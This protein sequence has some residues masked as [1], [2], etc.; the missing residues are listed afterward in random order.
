MIR[1]LSRVSPRTARA[2]AV[3][4]ALLVPAACAPM[5][6]APRQVQASNPTVTYTY[7]GDQEL[8][9]ANQ[10]GMTYCSQYHSVVRTSKITDSPDGS[11][12]V[13]FECVATAPSPVMAQPYN[14]N[15]AYAY[16]TDQ[17]LLDASRNAEIYC[18]NNGSQRATSTAVTNTNGSKS[19]TFQCT[20]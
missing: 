5:N 6:T 8:L 3:L 20:R 16:R 4:A 19:V 12:T 13:V 10:N 1:L 17:E 15:I 14:P 11:K 9:Q 2:A 7:R 18:M